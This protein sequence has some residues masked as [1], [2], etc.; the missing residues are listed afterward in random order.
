MKLHKMYHIW[1]GFTVLALSI[2]ACIGP[3]PV[4]PVPTQAPQAQPT[5]NTQNP[6]PS[7][8]GQP[9]TSRADLIKAT[10]Q[11]Y[12]LFDI[13]GKLTPKYSGSGTILSSTGM[14][15]T[16]AHVASPAS[17]GETD[18]EPDALAIALVDKEDQPPVFLYFAKVKA[19]DGYLDMAVI[20]ITSTLDGVNVDPNSLNLPYVQVGNS[21]S[22]HVADHINIFGFP[23]IGG[24]TITYTDGSVSG[25]T[26]EESLGDRAWIKTD[27]GIAGGNS[28]GLAANDA[29][30]IIGIPTLAS[31]GTDV[32]KI[33][34][35]RVVQDTN[36]DGVVDDKDMCIPIG[37]FINA[38]RPVNFALPLIKAVQSGQAYTSPYGGPS[39]PISKG[40]G[41]ETFGTITWYSTTGGSD[42]KVQD[43]ISAYPS[44][45]TSMAAAFS[46]SG[47]TNGE[48][49]AEK[50]T[51][52]GQELYSTMSNPVQ[53]SSG[54]QGNTYTCLF[55]SQSGMPEGNYHIEL[56]AG[57]DLKL[58]TQSDV[59]VGG[60]SNPVPS[61]PSSG[62]GVVTVS[63]QVLDGDSMNPI[64][65]AQIF[66]LNPGINFAQWKTDQFA[67]ADIFTFATADNQGN[68]QLPDKLALNVG[69]TIIIYAEGY[70]VTYGDNLSWT[71][72][73]P[74]N[75]QMTV[76]LS[77]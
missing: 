32:K 39:Q 16:N 11:I 9:A 57:Q 12:G 77:K 51:V 28:G 71:S 73:D 75:F 70:K 23:G 3:T 69:Y 34:D 74:V 18:M 37:E 26:P 60:G 17:Q 38:I 76:K 47:M 52:G 2:L 54:S 5:Q 33:T 22:L 61:Q 14:I 59:V 21:D 62:Q 53:W 68:F 42:C 67:N 45:T 8:N 20:Q 27:A 44:G 58:L 25:F 6:G 10:V 15:L 13:N 43:P 56:Y 49:W 48:P 41:G 1:I 35:C 19:V 46:F 66:I 29:G 4:Q 63:G 7:N 50:W 30:F 72:Q 40:S 36:G 24:S 64:P 31:A 65:G 55:N